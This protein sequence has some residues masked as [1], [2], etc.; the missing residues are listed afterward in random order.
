MAEGERLP[1]WLGVKFGEPKEGEIAAAPVD[2]DDGTLQRSLSSLVHITELTVLEVLQRRFAQEAI[3]TY[4]ALGSLVVCNPFKPVRCLEDPEQ[5]PRFK[6]PLECA[7]LESTL[8]SDSEPHIWAACRNAWACQQRSGCNVSFVIQGESGAGKTETAKHIMAY[9]SSPVGQALTGKR[10]SRRLSMDTSGRC[11]PDQPDLLGSGKANI[12]QV[13]MCANPLTEALGNARTLR[14]DNS[15]RFGRFV[16]LFLNAS[17][18]IC[19]SQI[20]I[21]LLEKSRVVLQAK[22][23]RNF[24]IF[25]QMLAGVS[26]EERLKHKLRNAPQDYC[27]LNACDCFE[28]PGIDDGEEWHRGVLGALQ[29]LG[30][31]QE[32]HDGLLSLL[33]A[34]LLCGEIQWEGSGNT[35]S[36]ACSTNELMDDLSELLGI[37]RSLL[38]LSLSTRKRKMPRGS[39]V[40]SPLTP[41]QATDLTLSIARSVYE[42]LFEWII[43]LINEVSTRGEHKSSQAWMGVLDIFGFEAFKVNSLEQLFINYCN[44]RLHQF[45][46]E[47]AYKQEQK[48]CAA[49]GVELSITFNDN[50]SIL[51]AIDSTNVGTGLGILPLLEEQCGLQSGSN[52]AFTETCHRRFKKNP[53]TSYVEPKIAARERFEINH[54]CCL[55]QYSTSNFREKNMDIMPAD[56]QQLLLGSRHSLVRHVLQGTTSSSAGTAGAGMIT[57]GKRSYIAGQLLRSISSLFSILCSSEPRFI[58]CVKSNLLKQ[59]LVMDKAAVTVQMHTLSIIESLETERQGYTYKKPFQDFLEEHRPL[60][61]AVHGCLP[62][63]KAWLQKEQHKKGDAKKTMAAEIIDAVGAPDARDSTSKVCTSYQLGRSKVL[64]T[65]KM[66]SR[67]DWMRRAAHDVFGKMAQ[68]LQCALRAYQAQTSLQDVSAVLI[69]L[70]ARYRRFA[71]LKAQVLHRRRHRR[72]AG[73]WRATSLCAWLLTSTRLTLHR[74]RMQHLRGT[75]RGSVHMMRLLLDIRAQHRRTRRRRHRVVLKSGVQ[76]MLVLQKVRRMHRFLRHRHLR[77]VLRAVVLAMCWLESI[78]NACRRRRQ[79]ALMASCRAA[80]SLSALFSRARRRTKAAVEIQRH[81]RTYLQRNLLREL[82]LVWLR[83]KAL[84]H[85]RGSLRCCEARAHMYCLAMRDA[86]RSLRAGLAMCAARGQLWQARAAWAVRELQAR[87][88][89]I[90]ARRIAERLRLAAKVVAL[91]DL[92]AYMEAMRARLRFAEY[93][94]CEG[95]VLAGRAL[96]QT[97]SLNQLMGFSSRYQLLRSPTP[98]PPA[99]SSPSSPSQRRQKPPR[100]WAQEHT[101]WPQEHEL[102]SPRVGVK[103]PTKDPTLNV[104]TKEMAETSRSPSRPS[105]Q[106]SSRAPSRPTSPAPAQL[107][108]A[109]QRRNASPARPRA[110][111]PVPKTRVRPDRERSVSPEKPGAS[112]E[113]L[114]SSGPAPS[115]PAPRS[116][117]TPLDARVRKPRDRVA[118]AIAGSVSEMAKNSCHAQL[119]RW[120]S[121]A[122][123]EA[124]TMYTSGALHGFKVPLPQPDEPE[125]NSEELRIAALAFS[126]AQRAEATASAAAAAAEAAWAAAMEAAAAAAELSPS[127]PRASTPR[128]LASP[129]RPKC[130]PGRSLLIPGPH[131]D[132]ARR[133]TV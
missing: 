57:S 25:Y 46:I 91:Q 81:V 42:S 60:S 49:E 14:N 6:E 107:R 128:A 82:R 85:I 53:L 131:R 3:Y 79:H 106:H 129:D 124:C 105:S 127:T 15:S 19:S 11:A 88:R 120:M 39:I 70:Q 90:K 97:K 95:F 69:Q 16:K 86:A 113:K 109:G 99:S 44:E 125:D 32:M 112:V 47:H 111:S 133:G 123:Q 17:G 108:S 50:A 92:K 38:V 114:A 56:L 103:P 98:P 66:H 115:G 1:G 24:H 30:A 94:R 65:A 7:E 75:V 28:I 83:R 5:L 72:L 64:L 104:P 54:S 43:S 9:F 119:H 118:P 132:G 51:E 33:S 101:A 29:G 41:A 26:E 20:S 73:I 68:D 8:P 89:G 116:Q 76:M 62:G 96:S 74:K 77:G 63:T 23:E 59:P 2:E 4:G 78:R 45:F 21:Y 31:D 48:V 100:K 93:K 27:M 12:Q 36:A 121:K 61:L 37:E 58:K 18:E 52:E 84:R 34:T 110:A 10:L 55:V 126:R 117:S 67:C 80:V 22:G 40:Q 71:A 102:I 35:E 13:M 87:W 130:L 122:R